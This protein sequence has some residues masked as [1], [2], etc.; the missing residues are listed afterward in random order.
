M[1][2]CPLAHTLAYTCCWLINIRDFVFFESLFVPCTLPPI[3]FRFFFI[4]F[5]FHS[6]PTPCRSLI[7]SSTLEFFPTCFSQL[8]FS[9]CLLSV[10]PLLSVAVRVSWTEGESVLAGKPH[11]IPQH[12]TRTQT[13]THVCGGF[14]PDKDR[15][16][17]ER[18]F[19]SPSTPPLSP[20][21]S[22][23]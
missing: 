2:A 3:V 20:L 10:L 8:P 18:L 16:P 11:T 17:W 4:S 9:A 12:H 14:P 5:S 1:L 19:F 6:P 13:I 21:W 7:T 23:P 15:K 22:R